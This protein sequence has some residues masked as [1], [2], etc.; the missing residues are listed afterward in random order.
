MPSAAMSERVYGT[1]GQPQHRSTGLE[2][3]A[4]V[5][6]DAVEM[7]DR[8]QSRLSKRMHEEALVGEQLTELLVPRD[9]LRGEPHDEQERLVLRVADG[10][11]LDLDPVVVGSRHGG[12]V[13]CRP[14]E[15]IC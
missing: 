13:A 14:D 3:R 7:R 10:V 8:P 2:E 4:D 6:S 5:D 15:P 11:E 1:G 9:Q 12:I